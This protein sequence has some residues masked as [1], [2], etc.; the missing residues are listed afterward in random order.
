MSES[1]VKEFVITEE[2]LLAVRKAQYY[3]YESLCDRWETMTLVEIVSECKEVL[4]IYDTLQQ[5][6]ELLG[7]DGLDS[8]GFMRSMLFL[9]SF[10]MRYMADT[11]FNAIKSPTTCHVAS[12]RAFVNR[13]VL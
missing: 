5:A 13:Q 11:F 6:P 1:T 9:Q 7:L 4:E 8:D 12:L 3:D 10:C 2:M